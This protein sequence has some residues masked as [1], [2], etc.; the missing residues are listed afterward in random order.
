MAAISIELVN[1]SKPEDRIPVSF[2]QS[3]TSWWSRMLAKIDDLFNFPYKQR[4]VF[5]RRVAR[6]GF[7]EGGTLKSLL[8]EEYPSDM[9]DDST[10]IRI[11]GPARGILGC[12]FPHRMETERYVG[13]V[14][15]YRPLEL[16]IDP[17]RTTA[18]NP[19]SGRRLVY[20]QRT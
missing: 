10:M 8:V 18:T 5:P 9:G 19:Q 13:P 11:E 7:N 12:L 4:T 1:P 16:N 17:A 15:Q 2:E 20:I 3:K 14:S 6:I